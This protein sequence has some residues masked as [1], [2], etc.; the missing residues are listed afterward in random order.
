M[1]QFKW[2]SGGA[3]GI[4]PMKMMN[5]R[6]NAVGGT[7]NSDDNDDAHCDFCTYKSPKG[8]KHGIKI[9]KAM[10]HYVCAKCGHRAESPDALK[11]H[12]K[13]ECGRKSLAKNDKNP[14]EEKQKKGR[15][16]EPPKIVTLV[17]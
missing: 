8:G 1:S 16:S 12:R 9:H 5:K 3:N 17:S 14:P 7:P 15:E 6:S 4:V 2:S 13:K 11:I 10:Q